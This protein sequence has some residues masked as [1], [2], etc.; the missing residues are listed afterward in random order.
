MTVPD[1]D[2]LD[3]LLDALSAQGADALQ[4]QH[5]HREGGD[6]DIEPAYTNVSDW[7][8]DWLLPTVERRYAEGSRGGIYWC[9]RWWA[10]PEALQRIYS[11]WREWEKARLDDTMSLWWR[12]HLDPHLATLAGE[13]GA[14]VMCSPKRHYTPSLLPAEALP[15]SILVLLPEG[16]QSVDPLEGPGTA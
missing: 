3:A 4:A 16:R 12:D 6:E 7:A 1:R 13:N 8:A 10:H 15:D 5:G 9:S 14:F 11:L 2:D